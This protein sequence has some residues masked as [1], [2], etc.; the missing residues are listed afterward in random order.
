MNLSQI[1]KYNAAALSLDAAPSLFFKRELEHIIPEMFEFEHARINA[2]QIFPIDRSAGP[3]A[4]IITFRQI[5]KTGVAKIISDYADDIP[6]VNVFGEEFTGKIRSI[7]IAAKWSLQEIRAASMA[8]RPL[9]RQQAEAAR[10]TMLRT[11]NEVAF[12]GDAKHGLVGLFTDPNIP[13]AAISGAVWAGKAPLDILEDMND[14]ANDIVE[15]TN[16]VEVPDTLI[17][18]TKQFNQIASTNVGTGTDTTIL[19]YFLNNNPYISTVMNVRELKGAGTAGV[20]VMVAYNR[21]PSKLRLNV[22]LDME[23]L[24]PEQKG[25]TTHVPYHMRIGGLT[26]TK[27]LSIS[28]CEDI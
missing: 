17:M 27:P 14:C 13:T 12:N 11:E 23:Q 18:P 4:E 24:A 5:T 6:V 20:D 3:A 16:D 2:R 22:P 15:T 19:R 8:G 26:V 9:D 1:F 25:L 21:N 7:A 10:E 28:I